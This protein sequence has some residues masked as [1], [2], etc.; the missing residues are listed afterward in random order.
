MVCC[1]AAPPRFRGETRINSAA[2]A[3]PGSPKLRFQIQILPLIN[4]SMSFPYR[5]VTFD[6]F[7]TLIDWQRG[8]RDALRQMP[9]LAAHL[10][11]VEPILQARGP[12]EI[13]LL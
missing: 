6:C 1:T 8:Q 7:G 4:S 10:D 13:E 9:S 3:A 2:N 5:A 11:Q 12:I